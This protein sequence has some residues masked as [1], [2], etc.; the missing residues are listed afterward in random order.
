MLSSN[1][2]RNVYLYIKDL[3][4]PSVIDGRL[5]QPRLALAIQCYWFQSRILR[6]PDRFGFF[7]PG[8][9]RL[10]VEESSC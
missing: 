5:N 2:V 1:L 8:P 10:Q 6:L 4:G 7:A 9:P 3:L